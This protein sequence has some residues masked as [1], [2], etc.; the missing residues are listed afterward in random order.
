MS[1]KEPIEIEDPGT[2]P[3]EIEDPGTEP[4]ENENPFV[5]AR[6]T[7]TGISG[8]IPKAF[9]QL[10]PELF[11]TDPNH[12]VRDGLGCLLPPKNPTSKE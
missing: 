11:R 7:L 10:H 1:R 5:W 6:N 9:T 2:E 12:P 3:I 4:I 8:P